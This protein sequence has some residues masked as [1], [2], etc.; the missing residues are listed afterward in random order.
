MVLKKGDCIYK[1]ND[2]RRYYIINIFKDDGKKIVCIKFFGRDILDWHY[3][4]WEYDWL[5]KYLEADVY[6]LNARET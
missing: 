6:S 5:I 3:E 2:E 1:V 4:I